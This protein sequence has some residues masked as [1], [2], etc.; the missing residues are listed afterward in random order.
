MTFLERIKFQ[1]VEKEVI[2]I[3]PDG[4]SSGWI[5]KEEGQI[6]YYLP[7]YRKDTPM[8]FLCNTRIEDGIIK[9]NLGES[10]KTLYIDL[11]EKIFYGCTDYGK[12]MITGDLYVNNVTA[13][14]IKP[15]N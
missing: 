11:K 10:E 7:A 8:E 5:F 12:I 9:K 13:Y 15:R 1:S 3:E 2:K 14:N 6:D 4:N